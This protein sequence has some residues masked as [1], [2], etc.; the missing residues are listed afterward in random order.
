MNPVNSVESSI[1][2]QVATTMNDVAYVETFSMRDL[3]IEEI[4]IEQLL[5]QQ[6]L[7][8][9]PRQMRKSYTER[10]RDAREKVIRTPLPAGFDVDAEL[11]AFYC[12]PEELATNNT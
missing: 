1:P 5:Q 10:Y 2:L 4:R 12:T 6:E 8:G 7:I 9:D 3:A 11:D